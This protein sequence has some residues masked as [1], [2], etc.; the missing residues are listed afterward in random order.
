MGKNNQTSITPNSRKELPNRGKGKQTLILEAIREAA[1][2]SLGKDSTREE[3]EIAIFK[4]MAEAAFKPTADTALMSN[5]CLGQIMKK[6][7]P[8]VKSV[9]PCV[10]FD[11]DEDA[12]PAI[13]ASQVMKAA[14]NGFISPDIANTFISS[15]AA[16]LKIDEITSLQKRLEAIEESLGVNNG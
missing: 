6:G 15:I 14:A 4:F 13:Q 5:F 10:E 7:W 8:D 3:S 2:L 16:M 11:F 1:V 9:M 12:T